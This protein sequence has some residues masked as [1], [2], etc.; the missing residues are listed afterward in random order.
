MTTRTDSAHVLTCLACAQKNRVPAD[1]LTAAPRC[2]TCGAA[3]IPAKPV[4]LDARTHDRATAADTLPLLV[5]YWAPWCGPCRAMAPDFARAAALLEGSA[6]L[7]KLN[8]ETHP[9][10]AGRANIRGIPALI[11]YRNGREAG[12][13]TGAR[14]A[15]AIVDFVRSGGRAG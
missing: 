9:D 6:R 13:L 10:I 7:A 1:R 15:Q 4:E 8:T 2:A 11:L 5:D 14:P 3:L 12:R